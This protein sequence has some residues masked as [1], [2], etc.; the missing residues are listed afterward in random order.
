MVSKYVIDYAPKNCKK[1]E[2]H[3][4]WKIIYLTRYFDNK[5]SKTYIQLTKRYNNVF[6]VNQKIYGFLVKQSGHFNESYQICSHCFIVVI[7]KEYT[8]ICIQY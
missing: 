8:N 6:D 1:Y 7:K 5:D 3:I 4:N 2:N